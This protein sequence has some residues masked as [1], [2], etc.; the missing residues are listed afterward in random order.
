MSKAIFNTDVL[1]VG[2]LN[3]DL[4]MNGMEE[5][6]E[7]GK[8]K[9][10]GDME[11]ALGSSA[12]IFASNLSALNVKVAFIGK[13]GSDVLGQ[14]CRNQL[15]SRG[16]DTTLIVLDESLKTGVT[17]ALNYGEDRAMVTYQG[18]MKYLTIQDVPDKYLR[19]ARHL[20][21]SSFFLQPGFKDELGKLFQIAKSYGLSTS[22]D[23]QWDPSEKWDIDLQT[24]LPYVDIFLPN[25]NELRALT[26]TGSIIEGI[27][28]LKDKAGIM[29]VKDGT[30][31]ALIWDGKRIFCQPAFTHNFFVD[32]I[33]AGDSFNA[34]FV[35]MF[36][37]GKDAIECAEYA[38]LMGALNT[39]EAGGTG[40]FVSPKQV[41][42]SVLKKFNKNVD[43]V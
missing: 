1:V 18:A 2:E 43:Y 21:F 11:F 13:A 41:K 31:G 42:N 15:K 29:A 16:V 4:V 10:A 5:Y 17:I 33:G 27:N 28:V 8:E 36:L 26:K 12:A 7:I 32:A 23:P 39:T 14:F 40:A 24:I 20:H 9:L 25:A 34:G 37:Q 19:E 30:N 38:S 35:K 22:F 6:P 3:V